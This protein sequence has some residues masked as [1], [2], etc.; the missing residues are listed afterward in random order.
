MNKE[1]DRPRRLAGFRR[2]HPLAIHP[3]G[4]VA[5]LGPVF[6]APDLA[7]LGTRRARAWRRQGAGE[8]SGHEAKPGPLDDRAPRQRMIELFHGVL[9]SDEVFFSDFYAAQQPARCR[10]SREL[11]EYC[12]K[13]RR[14]SEVTLRCSA[15]Q[16]RRPAHFFIVTNVM[17]FTRL[18]ASMKLPSRVTDVLRTMFPPPGIAQLWNFAVLGSKRT[19]VFGVDP[20]SLYQMISLIAEMPYGS[21]L[22]PLGDGHSAT[23]P[24]AGSRRP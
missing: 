6:A 3:Q 13:P 9:Q 5:F 11:G 23:L 7:A 17:P 16:P 12:S 10:N 1:Q 24:V 22:G 8:T 15:Q 14:F 20:D 21:D 4:N 2:P 18:L 19:T